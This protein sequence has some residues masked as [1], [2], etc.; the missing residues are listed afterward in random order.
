M[1]VC[2]CVC[3][4]LA[5]VLCMNKLQTGV[6]NY[7]LQVHIKGLNKIEADKKNQPLAI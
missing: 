4:V 7:S 1:C 3:V 5:V 2:V 6:Y